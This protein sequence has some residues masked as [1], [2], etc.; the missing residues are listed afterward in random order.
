MKRLRLFSA[1]LVP[2]L[3]LFSLGGCQQSTS[4]STPA[5]SPLVTATVTGRILNQSASLK[6][7]S[8]ATIYI[9][10]NSTTTNANGVFSVSGIVSGN[11][12]LRAQ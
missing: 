4:P 11:Y 10:T 1:M 7:V 3:A 12:V 9:G 6:P 2:A 5:A 8:G